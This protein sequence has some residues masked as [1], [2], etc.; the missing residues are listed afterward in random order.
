MLEV[1]RFA[2]RVFDADNTQ[3]GRTVWIW[4]KAEMT[5]LV[6]RWTVPLMVN[7][8]EVMQG[9]EGEE[10]EVEAVNQQ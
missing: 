10:A 4:V 7:L 8:N 9:G 1:H 6:S 3:N 5:S 2:R